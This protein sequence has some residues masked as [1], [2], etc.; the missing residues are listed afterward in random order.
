[1][2]VMNHISNMSSEQLQ[3]VMKLINDSMVRKQSSAA[4]TSKGA[5]KMGMQPSS[6]LSEYNIILPELIY[7]RVSFIFSISRSNR[8]AKGTSSFIDSKG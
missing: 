6:L 7:V 4:V 5:D 1:M 8:F 3:E 2:E